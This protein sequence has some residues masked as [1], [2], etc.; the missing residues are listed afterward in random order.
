MGG[1]LCATL[2]KPRRHVCAM[3]HRLSHSVS[4]PLLMRRWTP[5]VTSAE[6]KT[7][8]DESCRRR[9]KQAATLAGAVPLAS[10]L[11]AAVGAAT[12]AAVSLSANAHGDVDATTPEPAPPEKRR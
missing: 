4:N 10:A 11:G 7:W 6:S 9:L 1:Q 8:T 5:F 3:V 2:Y 12:A